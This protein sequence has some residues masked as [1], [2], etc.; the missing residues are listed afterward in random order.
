MSSNTTALPLCFINFGVAAEVAKQG[1]CRGFMFDVEQYN[2][3]LFAYG[4]QKHRY[5]C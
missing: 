4:K 2:E 3:G 1:G 5:S